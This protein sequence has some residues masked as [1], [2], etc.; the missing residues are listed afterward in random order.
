MRAGASGRQERGTRR[1]ALGAALALV[2][3]VGVSPVIDVVTAAP[4]A[5]AGNVVVEAMLAGHKGTDGNGNA[6]GTDADA[7]NCIRFAPAS[8]TWSTAQVRAAHGREAVESRTR[9]VVW[10]SWSSDGNQCPS[11]LGVA[12]EWDNG[13]V[14]LPTEYRTQGQSIIGFTPA[15][16]ATVP[17]GGTFLLG[18]FRHYNNPIQAAATFFQGSLGI[19]LGGTTLST[20][21]TLNETA[22]NASPA[23]NPANNDTV[24]FSQL[25]RTE[26]VT[27]NGISYRLS[28]Q[29]FTTAGTGDVSCPATP[30]GTYATTVSTVEQTTTVACLWAR[31]DQVRPLTIVKQT[32]AVGDAPTA[33]PAATF[34][35]TSTLSGSPWTAP[36]F[37][38]APT[39]VTAPSNTAALAA[40]AFQ[41]T[42]ERVTITESAPAA[43]W[44]LTTISCRDGANAALTSGVTLNLTTRSLVLEN[45]PEAASAAA[46][47][48][49]CTFLNSYVAPTTLTLVSTTIPS[50]S[51]PAPAAGWTFTVDAVA[52][53]LV[54]AGAGGSVTAT[55]PV[56]SPTRTVQVTESVQS[57]YVFDSL[58][59]RRDD[60]PS[61]VV[62]RTVNPS[63]VT[64]DRGRS[65]TCT[66]LNLRPAVDLVKQAFLATDTG[67]TTPL[68][69][70]QLRDAGTAVVWRY[71][72][73]NTGQTTLTGT[74]LRDA[75][76][77]TVGGVA[78][79]GFTSISC[80][81]RPDIAAGTTVTI[82]SLAPGQ[83][84]RCQASGVL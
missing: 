66:A 5:A 2:L 47:P 8:G 73:T 27:L 42:G 76:T 32:A 12:R 54:T 82:P 80:P 28:V 46:A 61:I 39:G 30:T 69:A 78:T 13:N 49:T 10:G 60:A 31:L 9:F 33:V 1:A 64:L 40:R 56:T 29:G 77:V 11:T 7:S 51:T 20:P 17:S 25:V 48:I 74:V 34:S 45:V 37:S 68:A 21:Y 43:R 16:T 24:A 55:V 67:F 23:N 22:N 35:S 52:G 83:Q 38:L 53:N 50:G 75:T 6:V 62:T 70:G 4:A 71:T 15:P 3:G 19:R 41:A 18:T 14:L 57:G 36:N 84:I 63:S 72:V 59:C 79:P 44:E 58:T 65:Y 26:T 81:G